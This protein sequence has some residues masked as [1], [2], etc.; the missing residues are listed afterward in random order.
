M[1]ITNVKATSLKGYKDWNFVRIETDKGIMGL[2]EAHPGEGITDVIVKRLK[3]LLVGKDPLNV[4]PLYHHMS[5]SNDWPICGWD[6]VRGH[7]RGR[8]RSMGSGR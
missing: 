4:E 8:N 2:G 3:P 5:W 1:K 6:N 7:W